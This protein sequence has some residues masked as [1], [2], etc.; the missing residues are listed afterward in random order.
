[1]QDEFFPVDDD[2]VSGVVSAGIASHDRKGLGEYVD[3]LALALV[4][5]L[6]SDNDRS[7]T[8]GSSASSASTQFELQLE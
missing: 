4:A 1:L 2:S 8:S 5:P 6:G 7:S 3:D